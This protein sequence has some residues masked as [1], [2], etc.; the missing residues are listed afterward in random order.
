M[1]RACQKAFLGAMVLAAYRMAED[2]KVNQSNFFRRFKEILDL[3]ISEYSRPRGMKSGA[4]EPL[5]QDWAFWLRQKGFIPSA[6]PGDGS[7]IYINYPISQTL[8]R[9]SDKDQL[10]KIFHEKQWK[11]QWDEQTLIVRVRQETTRFSQHLQELFTSYQF[12]SRYEAI[13]EAIHEV[14]E[15]WHNAGCPITLKAALT[16]SRHLFAGL[17]RTEDVF[18]ETIEYFIYPKQPRRRQLK[19]IEIQHKDNFYP[20]IEERLGWY[21][22]MEWIISENELEN[23][24][25]YRAHASEELDDLILPQRDFWI[26]VSDPT[27]PESVDYASWGTPQLGKTFVLL[28]QRALLSQLEF[29]QSE[30][31]L[32]WNRQLHPFGENSN[33][34]ELHEC[35]VISPA[36]EGVFIK[37]QALKYALQPH[38]QLSVNFSGGYR[39]VGNMPKLQRWYK[40]FSYRGS[41]QKLVE[42]IANQV[43]QHNLNQ[44]VPGLRIEKKEANSRKKFY[45]FLAIE[46]TQMGDIPSEVK[47]NLIENPA[48]SRFFKEKFRDKIVDD[49]NFTYKDI[50][51]MVEGTNIP[52]QLEEQVSDDNP[53]DFAASLIT[54]KPYL[55]DDG[56]DFSHQYERLLY[57]LSALGAGSWE[58]FKKVCQ[59]LELAEPRRILRRLK[60]LGHLESSADGSKWSMAPIALVK[61]NSQSESQEFVLC[62]Q[63]SLK[64]VQRLEQL[65]TVT[66]I[67][68]RDA[69]SYIHLQLANSKNV[70]Y[71]I[72]QINT[73]FSISDAGKASSKLAEILP[74]ID[75]WQQNLKNLPG[76]VPSSYDWKYFDGNDFVDCISPKETGMYQRSPR[77]IN[78]S[79]TRTLFYDQPNDK[80]L[81]GDWYGLRF[82]IP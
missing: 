64:L 22:P 67:N 4:E 28:C 51:Y 38:V 56:K 63:R 80:W 75:T 42:Q 43:Q 81:Q 21:E 48:C 50:K 73:E 61:V 77:E 12:K 20:L 29:L 46:S 74:D 14:Y 54:S 79:F 55:Q 57:W 17:Y 30:H 76:I 49:P 58:S 33:W 44:I 41:S 71:L 72:E 65:T 82:L 18:S 40:G 25:K 1:S 37:N 78:N 27:N 45:F 39:K 69:P 2:E 47:S 62:G 19:Q 23:G 34:I 6:Q 52:Y 26:L 70:S 53:F 15:Q 35:M 60:L 5:W 10:C 7:R 31:L 59:S 3:P 24:A 68:Q 36:Y 16:P 11:T 8:L 66:S 9:Q 32:K 13:S